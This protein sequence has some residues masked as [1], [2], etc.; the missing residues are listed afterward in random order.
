MGDTLAVPEHYFFITYC[1]LGNTWAQ[2]LEFCNQKI[3]ESSKKNSRNYHNTKKYQKTLEITRKYQMV[4]ESK[5][6]Y[7]KL[8]ESTKKYHTD[9]PEKNVA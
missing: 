1:Q 7:Q 9:L 8:P 4:P 2:N 6:K 3:T 5:K